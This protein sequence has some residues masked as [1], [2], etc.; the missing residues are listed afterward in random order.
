LPRSRARA[1]GSRAWGVTP[2]G[3]VV[4]ITVLSLAASSGRSADSVHTTYSFA[5]R[6]APL[7]G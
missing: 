2:V 5:A 7:S 6:L 1:Q 4:S 3:K